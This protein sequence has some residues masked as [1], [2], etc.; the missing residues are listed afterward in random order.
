[1]VATHEARATHAEG[2]LQHERQ[3]D[4]RSGVV[5]TGDHEKRRKPRALTDLALPG[6]EKIEPLV[7]CSGMIRTLK[8]APDRFSGGEIVDDLDACDAP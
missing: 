4:Q 3:Q 5:I 8:T 7:G 1:M 6:S 2:C